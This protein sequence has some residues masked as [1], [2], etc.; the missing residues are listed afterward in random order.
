MIRVLA[1]IF[2]GLL[3][4]AP[5]SAQLGYTP[6]NYGLQS[7]GGSGGAL[8]ISG[9]TL[10]TT[11][12]TGGTA[13]SGNATVGLTGTGGMTT[14]SS[15]GLSTSV[16]PCN[17]TNGANNSS[18]SFSNFTLSGPS[19]SGTY[20]ICVTATVAGAS[21]SPL[22][23]AFTIVGSG[24]GY[25]GIA[26]AVGS[27]PV[28]YWGVRAMST[29]EASG[30]TAKLMNVLNTSSGNA[31][32]VLVA[33]GGG[34]GLTATGCADGVGL[35]F[36]SW[37]GSS[38]GHV[39]TLY[40]R[41][42][43]TTCNLTQATD[44][45]RPT[46]TAAG[47]VPTFNGSSMWMACSLS[48]ISTPFTVLGAIKPAGGG[49]TTQGQF[50]NHTDNTLTVNYTGHYVNWTSG[51]GSGYTA[52]QIDVFDAVNNSFSANNA[53][54]TLTTGNWGA[55]AGLFASSTSRTPCLTATCGSSD[56]AS[57]NPT[58][59]NQI[60][61]GARRLAGSGTQDGYYNG[62]IGEVAIYGSTLSGTNLTNACHN[63]NGYGWS[64]ASC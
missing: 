36:S 46:I 53:T 9:V 17:G 5:A 40:D 44:A 42:S 18:F 58:A 33:T 63:E 7:S 1:T 62:S 50:F 57:E 37:L 35:T 32:D 31:C 61:M 56:S 27:T 11:T 41:G 47:G 64:T 39:V 22:G 23:T 45:A 49:D 52:N 19:T 20:A 51:S 25:T 43:G 54:G 13:Y 48:A 29:S 24:G 26:D 38:T 16:S 8:T 2:L 34:I 15:M 60:G 3:L 10:S 14:A 4:T 59:Q 28:H 30:A 12:F 6:G 55:F 21:N